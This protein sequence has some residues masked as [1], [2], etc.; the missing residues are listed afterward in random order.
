MSQLIAQFGI[1]RLNH[2]EV[3]IAPE[4][5]VSATMKLQT[6]KGIENIATAAFGLR[7]FVNHLLD[8]W[9]NSSP[10]PFPALIKAGIAVYRR[11]GV[12]LFL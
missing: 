5:F 2:I 7:R 11:E 3:C 12:D 9:M 8:S 4:D 6:V 10:D 1:V